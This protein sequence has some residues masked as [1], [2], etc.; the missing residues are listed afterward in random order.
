MSIPL[1]CA[2]QK[3]WNVYKVPR[4]PEWRRFMAQRPD[5]AT[6]DRHLPQ[7]AGALSAHDPY[8]CNHNRGEFR[9][10]CRRVHTK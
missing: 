1:V 10:A 8:D 2:L 9:R 4:V 3:R 5:A 7:R 6:P